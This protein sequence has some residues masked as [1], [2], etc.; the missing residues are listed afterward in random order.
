MMT[1]NDPETDI[2]LTL[3][4][5]SPG[6]YVSVLYR[7]SFENTVG[8]GEIARNEQFLLFPT[9][10]SIRLEHFLVFSSTSK[11]SF[12]NGLNHYGK[13]RICWKPAFSHNAF[14]G[15]KGK[16]VPTKPC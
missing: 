12:G 5:T 9:V 10:F 3:S 15:I 1:M 13:R 16:V 4:Q 6:F 8:K 2:P 14:Y 11:L 7:K